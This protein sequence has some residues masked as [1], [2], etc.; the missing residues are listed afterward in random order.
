MERKKEGREGRGRGGR[1]GRR[2]G[3]KEGGGVGGKDEILKGLRYH[4]QEK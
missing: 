3:A 1:N 4:K 2:E